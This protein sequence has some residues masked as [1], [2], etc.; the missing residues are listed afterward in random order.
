MVSNDYDFNLDMGDDDNVHGCTSIMISLNSLYIV[1]SLPYHRWILMH[2]PPINQCK[3]NFGL[4]TPFSESSNQ[5]VIIT[6]MQ[7]NYEFY[8]H[9]SKVITSQ[10]VNPSCPAN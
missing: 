9:I 6:Y 3:Y 2:A 8:L 10:R 4:Y 5:Y 1:A 7:C